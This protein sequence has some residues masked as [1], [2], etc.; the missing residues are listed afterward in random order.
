MRLL[1]DECAGA[2][3]RL[4]ALIAAGHDVVR[5]VDVLGGGVDDSAVFA[6]ACNDDR[7]LITFNASDF[8]ELAKYAPEHAGLLLIYRDDRQEDLSASDIVKAIA[9]VEAM[10]P[11]GLKGRIIALNQYRW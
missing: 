6:L 8:I 1:L 9:N 10:N 5:A 4:I 2:R 7:A 11:V 3:K